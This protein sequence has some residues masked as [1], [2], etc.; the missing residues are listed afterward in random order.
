M[1]KLHLALNQHRSNPDGGVI[2]DG[3]ICQAIKIYAY[4]HEIVSR[5]FI[6]KHNKQDRARKFCKNCMRSAGI[7]YHWKPSG[8]LTPRGVVIKDEVDS[9]DVVEYI[10]VEYIPEDLDEAARDGDPTDIEEVRPELLIDLP[11]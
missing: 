5:E 6:I 10:P 2:N 8:W 1:S 3:S 11:Y 7:D 9:E 4:N